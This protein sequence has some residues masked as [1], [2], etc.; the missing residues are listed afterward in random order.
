MEHKEYE[1]A[2]KMASNAQQERL[3]L[4]TEHPINVS[5]SINSSSISPNRP[6]TNKTKSGGMEPSIGNS[7]K[8]ITMIGPYLIVGFFL[9]LSFFNQ[10]LKGIVYFIGICLALLL[11]KMIQPMFKHM[12]LNLEP[13]NPVCKMFGFKYFNDGIPISTLIYC[14]TASYLIFPMIQSG[15]INIPLIAFMLMLCAVDTSIKLMNVPKCAH[16]AGIFTGIVLGLITGIL[17]VTIVYGINN[18]VLYHTDYISDK[19]A[20]SMPGDQ[21]FKCRV[22]K[23]GELMTTM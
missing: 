15:I 23:N 5:N 9:M 4:R 18:Q 19:V 21:K 6:P 17:W 8:F 12:D 14:F 3:K 20:C 22:Y 10:N 13:D 16:T 2:K 11:S 7:L 1:N